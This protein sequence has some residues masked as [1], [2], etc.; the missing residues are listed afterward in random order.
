MKNIF[1]KSKTVIG[2][3]KPLF[4]WFYNKFSAT[5]EASVY[6]ARPA[7]PRPLL[8]RHKLP[9]TRQVWTECCFTLQNILFQVV[10]LFVSRE[11]I[12]ILQLKKSFVCYLS[13]N[14]NV[15]LFS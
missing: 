3:R 12:F 14:R 2:I 11:N 5:L 15:E 1:V 4:G 7:V 13:L 10:C 9:L 8:L 6:L